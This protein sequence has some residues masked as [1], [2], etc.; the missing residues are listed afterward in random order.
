M[1][2]VKFQSLQSDG[3]FSLHKNGCK[4]LDTYF[5][6][7]VSYFSMTVQNITLWKM[8]ES[9]TFVSKKRKKKEKKK[10]SW[11][12]RRQSRHNQRQWSTMKPTPE[13]E[14][15][16]DDLIQQSPTSSNTWVG[17]FWLFSW[18]IFLWCE[19]ITCSLAFSPNRKTHYFLFSKNC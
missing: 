17:P 5:S 8:H 19:W 18:R 2:S 15:Q 12:G 3:A 4:T 1:Q 11:P 13:Y 16:S 10:H 9:L 14:T 6:L 7:T